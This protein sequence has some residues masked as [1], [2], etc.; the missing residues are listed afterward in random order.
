[1]NKLVLYSLKSET[2]ENTLLGI[3][4]LRLKRKMNE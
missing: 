3:R 1:M 2:K 4:Y